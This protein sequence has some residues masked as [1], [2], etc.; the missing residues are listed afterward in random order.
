GAGHLDD[1]PALTG[2]LEETPA[3]EVVHGYFG[4]PV[5]VPEELRVGSAHEIDR[6][7]VHFDAGHMRGVMVKSGQYIGRAT[8]ADDEHVRCG[9]V[10]RQVRPRPYRALEKGIARLL[11]GA[12][13]D[14]E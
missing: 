4:P 9:F 1:I 10:A 11:V 6:A 2:S 8:K 7:S 14:K 3:V 12:Q 5:G 13:I